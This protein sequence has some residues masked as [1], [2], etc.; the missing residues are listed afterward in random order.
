M[1]SVDRNKCIGCG[2]CSEICEEVFGMG[3]D[4]KA[5]VKKQ[6]KTPCVAEAIRSCP[7]EAISEDKEA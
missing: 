4:G 7:V 3:E 6:K 5:H 2:L 1:A